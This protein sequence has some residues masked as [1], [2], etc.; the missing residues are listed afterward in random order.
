MFVT[1]YLSRGFAYTPERIWQLVRTVVVPYLIFECAFALFRVHVG[2]EKLEDLFADP[3]WPLWYL[4][5]L[6]F[7]RLMTPIFRPMRG[8][9]VVA[10]VHQPAGRARGWATPST[11]PGC[12][13]CCRSSCSA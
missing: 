3:H 7:W 6:F 9:V 10:I 12:S 8:G 13:G 4:S 11:W 1:G 2:G 5:A